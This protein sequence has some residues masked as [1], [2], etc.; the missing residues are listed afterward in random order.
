M[1]DLTETQTLFAQAVEAVQ[2]RFV[3]SGQGS[4]GQVSPG[5]LR[6]AMEQLLSVF[7]KLDET[8]GAKGA[9]PYDDPTELGE[10]GLTIAADLATWAE[11]LGL[12]G[13]KM[14]MEKVAAGIACWVA[15]HDGQLRELEAVVNGFAARANSTLDPAE[16]AAL[17]H[18]MRDVMAHVSPIVRADADKSNPGRP[19]R[20]FNLNL[21]IVATRTQ[22]ATLMHEAYDTLGN[23]LPEDAPAFFEEGLRQAEKPVYGP[24]VKALMQEYFARWTTRH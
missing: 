4:G 24:M 7:A 5:Q 10:H 8:H 17:Y 22:D 6:E 20:V 21:A 16:L 18:C 13:A 3:Q 1:L 12:R 19:W 23:H 9:L 11:R 15:R 14:D 2:T